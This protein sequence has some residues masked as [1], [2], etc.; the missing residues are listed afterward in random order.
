M[1]ASVKA[2]LGTR[3]QSASNSAYLI[4]QQILNGSED[5]HSSLGIDNLHTSHV[6]VGADWQD[7]SIR[8]V[9]VGDVPITLRERSTQEILADSEK[10]PMSIIEGLNF[11]VAAYMILEIIFNSSFFKK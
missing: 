8:K 3:S 7:C 2:V 6:L 10:L 1:D 11:A 9:L 4:L 5:W